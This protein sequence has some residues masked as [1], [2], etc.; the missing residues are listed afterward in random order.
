MS[1]G[2]VGEW[3]KGNAGKGAALVGSLLTGNVPGAIAAGVSM[4][5]SAT[6]TDDPAD[7]LATLQTDPAALLKLKELAYANEADIRAH[8]AE[9][10][11]LDLENEQKAHAEQQQTIRAGDQATDTQVRLTRPTM[12]KQSWTATLCY[13]IGCFGVHAITGQNLFDLT[14]AG[15]LSA[16]AWAYLG[17]RTGDKWADAWRGKAK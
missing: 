13:C 11:R 8:I 10:K 15:I 2:G 3:I 7:A 14:I 1:W 6:G 4:V 12:A 17:F 9:T 5:A 16:P